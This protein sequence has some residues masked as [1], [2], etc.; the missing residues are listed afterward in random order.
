MFQPLKYLLPPKYAIQFFLPYFLSHKAGRLH[1]DAWSLRKIDKD[2][3]L[4]LHLLVI[5]PP[6]Q[7]LRM[8]PS[9]LSGL[10]FIQAVPPFK[11]LGLL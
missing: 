6:P 1:W 3:M 5:T 10:F 7:P 11:A 9:G 2:I 8:A 4:F